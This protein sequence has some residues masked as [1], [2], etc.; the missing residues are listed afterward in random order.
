MSDPRQR[1]LVMALEELARAPVPILAGGT[2][3]YPALRDGPAP[4]RVLDVTGIAGL[5]GIDRTASGWRFGAGTTWTDIIK[6]PLPPVFD[7]L[8]A[9]AREVGSVQI[10]NAGT[11]AGNLCNASP[12]ADGVPPLL[13]LDATVELASVRGSRT[14]PLHEFILGPR[15]TA[16]AS[17]ELMVAIQV[18][19]VSEQAR[20]GFVKL[21]ARRYLVISIVMASITLVPD[22]DGKLQDA[23]VAVGACSAVAQRLREL[24]HALVGQFISDDLISLVTPALL[25]TLTP[26]DDVRGSGDYRL[27]AVEQLIRRLLAACLL[28]L[29]GNQSGPALS[30][31][32]ENDP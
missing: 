3:F 8:K 14:L 7:G 1:S 21:G 5:R 32:S 15:Q 11:L 12:A 4:E 13:C 9:A 22:E 24:E 28:A 2:D 29:P 20:S 25:S 19:E 26:I 18:P 16:R 17:D 6:A 27:I 10:Q 30:S 31:D 23:R